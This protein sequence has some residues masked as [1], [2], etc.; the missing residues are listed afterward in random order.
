MDGFT[1]ADSG[2]QWTLREAAEWL[3]VGGYSPLISGSPGTVADE[4]TD[5]MNETGIDG[6]NVK[7]IVS[8]RDMTAFVDL[9][10]PELQDRGVYKTRYEEGTF[11]EKLYGRGQ[12]HLL[13]EHPGAGYK[14]TP[15]R[16]REARP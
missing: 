2:R 3:G 8:P 14:V 16:R 12:R 9:V 7:Y 11:R 6:F 10:V 1:N 4:V 13:P 5:W 15:L